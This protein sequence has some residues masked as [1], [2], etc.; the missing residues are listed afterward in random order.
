MALINNPNSWN[1]GTAVFNANPITETYL[2]LA[3]HRE[4]K[5]QALEQYHQKQLERV[6]RDGVRDQD[7]EQF[8]QKVNDWNQHWQINKDP[9]R[10]GNIRAQI[11]NDKLYGDLLGFVKQSKERS[12]LDKAAMP[13]GMS[14]KN[15]MGTT[16]DQ[17]HADIQAN[18][19]PIGAPG[20]K[21]IDL[22][23]YVNEPDDWDVEKGMK[24]YE[25]IPRVPSAPIV[26]ATDPNTG[27]RLITEVEGFDDKS[28]AN[29]AAMAGSE[30]QNDRS[31]NKAV[32]MAVADPQNKQML[33]EVYQ[34]Q[35]GKQPEHPEEYAT[36]FAI[37]K[38]PI[39]QTQ[40]LED[41]KEWAA[42]KRQQEKVQLQ[43]M[44]EKTQFGL[45]AMRA[46]NSREMADYR[47]KLKNASKQ[48]QDNVLDATFHDLEETAKKTGEHNMMYQGKA[49][50]KYYTAPVPDA[51]RGELG[52]RNEK[53]KLE[54]P[55]EIAFNPDN[56]IK[57]IYYKTQENKETGEVNQLPGKHI[58]NS[59]THT[60]TRDQ[61]KALIG[62][63]LFGVKTT[64]G[65][66]Y[67]DD[68]FNDGDDDEEFVPAGVPLTPS[69]PKSDWKSRAKKIK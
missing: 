10:K 14:L 66:D 56:T 4:A 40:K 55:D 54:Y 18:S 30:F 62:K 65:A 41:D 61:L 13:V 69:Q 15:K 5:N 31:F 37:S 6:D 53:G 59:K 63:K 32:Q 21:K 36:A 12:E 25:R 50:G 3:A 24:P 43:G 47:N 49:V 22:N 52:K 35:Y 34:E 67:G 28:K 46:K 17:F 44:R 23:P 8:Q 9:I 2:K 33:K 48:E 27:K 38:M 51:I 16:P 19:L 57:I 58:D 11:D 26:G 68:N 20:S 64:S 42:A 29:I 7:A 1:G 39:K 45:Q 60:I